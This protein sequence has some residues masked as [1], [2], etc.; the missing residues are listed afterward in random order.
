VV[1]ATDGVPVASAASIETEA[2]AVV[3]PVVSAQ[4]AAVVAATIGVPVALAATAE[5]EAEA[6]VMDVASAQ[7]AARRDPLVVT[8]STCH[9]RCTT[10]VVPR[11]NYI[12][13]TYFVYY[14]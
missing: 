3:A 8:R 2:E 1:A 12:Q 10:F 13:S 14:V 9:A 7:V 5:T 6:V 4:V 11:S